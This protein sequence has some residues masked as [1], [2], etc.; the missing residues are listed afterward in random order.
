MVAAIQH[1]TDTEQAGGGGH[2][3][4]ILDGK[5]PG[6]SRG[7]S[8]RVLVRYIPTQDCAHVRAY[9]TASATSTGHATGQG[10]G[11]SVPGAF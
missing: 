8:D 11:I 2:A 5:S 3:L 4:V 7:Q 1:I 10:G 6:F 9:G